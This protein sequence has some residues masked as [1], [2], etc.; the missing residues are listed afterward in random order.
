MTN[1]KRT[2]N[3]TKYKDKKEETRGSGNPKDNIATQ[4]VHPD[5]QNIKQLNPRLTD[6]LS[7]EVVNG[8]VVIKKE[9]K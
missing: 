2:V 4:P 8:V 1:N 3:D 9:T 7:V 5:I 6:I